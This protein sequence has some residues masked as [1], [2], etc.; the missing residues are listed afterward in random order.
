M[1]FDRNIKNKIELYLTKY[2]V[3][4]ITGPR[5]SGKTTFLK[6]TL[7]DFRYISLENPDVR[8]FA[9]E[10]PN[11]FLEEYN[12][13]VIFDEVQKAPQLFSYLQTLVDSQ[14]KMGQFVLSG[15]QNFQLMDNI[16]QSLAGRVGI[17]KLFPLD[18]TELKKS[19][20]LKSDLSTQIFYGGYPA[21]Y[22]RNIEPSQYFSDYLETYVNRDIRNLKN[23]HNMDAFM[24]LVK[25][26]ATHA[27]QLVNYSQFSKLIGVSHTTI[28]DWISLL[29]TSF[30][31]FDI[32]P[33]YRN[34]NKRLVKS[35]KLYFYD[36]GLLCRLLGLN[37]DQLN[38]L[39]KNWGS[40]FE[41]FIVA[42]IIKNNAHLHQ[43]FDFYFWRDSNGHEL[44]L[45]FQDGE[46][47]NLIEIKSSATIKSAMFKNIDYVS[48]LVK[49][50]K[51]K[52][53]LIYGGKKNQIRTNYS[54]YS[55]KDINLN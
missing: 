16:S 12:T 32:P 40:L 1:S 53:I 23:I 50:F 21:I 7:S 6:N 28:R 37:Q 38:P 18:L 5:Q 49:E 8:S 31:L 30:I 45:L 43:N 51:T 33:Y 14:G 15:S 2:P 55:W 34:F 54:I 24:R 17:F 19:N 41:N 10:D 48:N 13:K 29:K 20:L 3:L 42:E 27:G 46:F 25:I 11:S 47:I 44:D 26:C 22:D 52:K 9:L 36:T 4:V 39:Y 35:S